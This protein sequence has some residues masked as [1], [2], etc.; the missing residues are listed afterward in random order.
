MANALRSYVILACIPLGLALLAAPCPGQ[1]TGLAAPRNQST[2]PR[3]HADQNADS[4]RP[5]PVVTALAS[6][7]G[8]DLF[9][10]AGDDHIVRIW[11]LASGELR[12]RLE[13]HTD[14]VRSAEFSPDGRILATAGNDGRVIYWDPQSGVLSRELLAWD[15]PISAARFSPDGKL[16]AVVGFQNTL[17]LVDAAS[18]AVLSRIG[19]PCGDIRT[20]AFSADGRLLAAAGR[21]GVIRIWDVQTREKLRDI[22][23]HRRRVHSLVFLADSQTLISGA[24]DR[25]V[26]VWN[27]ETGE[28][29][30]TFSAAP[31]EVRVLTVLDDQ[32]LAVSGSDNHIHLWSLASGEPLGKLAGH[33]G[34]VTCLTKTGAVLISGGYDATVRVW[35]LAD[36]P[37]NDSRGDRTAPAV[38]AAL[39]SSTE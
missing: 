8:N 23:A 22:A 4:K 25:M 39:R 6:Q 17:A 18:G 36:L 21:S 38:E 27:A 28:S 2:W 19:C 24:D 29:L 14:W 5:P 37:S 11:S 3:V 10:S 13:G 32:I 26:G 9:A 35:P 30:Q 7:T 15:S 33:T 34:T 20:L 1:Q 16:L 31:C 12:W